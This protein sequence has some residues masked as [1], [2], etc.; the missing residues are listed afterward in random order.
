MD[1]NRVSKI[2][3]E[4]G[5]A[6]VNEGM[7]IILLEDVHLQQSS[8]ELRIDGRRLLVKRRQNS[9]T[10][11]GEIRGHVQVR[12]VLQVRMKVGRPTGK[13]IAKGKLFRSG[14]SCGCLSL[15]NSPADHRQ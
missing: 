2:T 12:K 10:A 11:A 5:T 6:N 9:E 14:T 1:G 7:Q 4:I 8:E 13:I 15:N 3:N